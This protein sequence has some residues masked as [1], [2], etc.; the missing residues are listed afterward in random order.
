MKKY[1]VFLEAHANI[2]I[3]ADSEEEAREIA[4]RM[5]DERSV[6]LDKTVDELMKSV[7]YSVDRKA[8]EFRD[9][10]FEW[11]EPEVVGTAVEV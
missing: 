6:Y 11:A 3:E 10:D 5:E 9:K 2:E 7:P 1:V 8:Y 4:T